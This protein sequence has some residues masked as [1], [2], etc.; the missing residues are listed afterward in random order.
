MPR[1]GVGQL[2]HVEQASKSFKD[3]SA[4]ITT[5]FELKTS[6][7]PDR[8]AFERDSL[9]YIIDVLANG[10]VQSDASNAS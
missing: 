7:K 1:N 5:L 2:I 8:H 10:G 9:Q 4:L 6:L 3:K